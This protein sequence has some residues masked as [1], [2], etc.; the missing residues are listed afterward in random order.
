MN[1]LGVVFI[2]SENKIED[3]DEINWFELLIPFALWR[4]FLNRKGRVKHAAIFEIILLGLLHLDDEAFAAGTD[5]KQIEDRTAVIFVAAYLFVAR[6][7]QILNLV[8]LRQQLIQKINQ[9]LF[10]QFAAEKPLKT[11]VSKWM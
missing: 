9:K 4:L 8:L 2:F 11:P 6:K 1:D 5:A 3:A 10:P 7:G